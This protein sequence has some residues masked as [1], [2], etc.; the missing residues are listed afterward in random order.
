MHRGLHDEKCAG[1]K[2]K[3]ILSGELLNT[4]LT[5]VGVNCGAHGPHQRELQDLPLAT[6]TV[7]TTSYSVATLSSSSYLIKAAGQSRISPQSAGF[8]KVV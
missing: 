1:R 4:H 7:F 5:V 3:S 6:L 2:I 8:G